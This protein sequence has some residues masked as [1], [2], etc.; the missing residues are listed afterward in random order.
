MAERVMSAD[1]DN[2]EPRV[3]GGDES[4]CRSV[5]RSVVTDLDHVG[6]SDIPGGGKF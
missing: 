3:D 1:R 2:C 4:G 6:P 5:S